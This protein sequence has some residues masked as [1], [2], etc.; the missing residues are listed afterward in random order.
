MFCI[1]KKKK[2]I[3]IIMALWPIGIPKKCIR[4]VSFYLRVVKLIKYYWMQIDVNNFATRLYDLRVPL[5][6]DTPTR[7]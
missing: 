6:I 1:V 2:I 5:T 4:S 7:T 3:I